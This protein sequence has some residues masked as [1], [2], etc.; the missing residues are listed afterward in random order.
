MTTQSTSS[1]SSGTSPANRFRSTIPITYRSDKNYLVNGTIIRAGSVYA[2]G[3][4]N[5][6]HLEGDVEFNFPTNISIPAE[7]Y[8]LLV[9]FDP[10]TNTNQLAAFRTRFPGL[11][12][13]VTVLGPYSG[14]LN[15]SGATLQLQRPDFPQGPNH[16]KDFQDV[17]YFT[18]ERLKYKDTLPW[19]PEADGTG[20]SLQRRKAVEYG[21]EP[22]AELESR[23]A[24][25][26]CAQR[27]A[28]DHYD[29][30]AERRLHRR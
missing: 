7:G 6:W 11:P 1:S 9:N 30:T 28:A 3:R 18:A 15:N 16:P 25:S 29:S 21:N 27:R 8:L 10:V 22:L 12:A 24:I 17:P 26:R 5:T 4:T 2:E 13:N 23:G 19:P 20:S 14:K